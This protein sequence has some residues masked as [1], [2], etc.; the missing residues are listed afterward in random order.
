MLQK[1]SRLIIYFIYFFWG[2]GLYHPPNRR[3]NCEKK[4]GKFNQYD[5]CECYQ[6]S[7]QQ[8]LA[9]AA[10]HQ[11]QLSHYHN[12]KGGIHVIHDVRDFLRICRRIFDIFS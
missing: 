5:F 3:K 9:R 8:I 4:P 10:C 1:N 6:N 2:G 7:L 11:G 12:W